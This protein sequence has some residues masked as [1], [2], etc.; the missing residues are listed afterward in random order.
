MEHTQQVKL[1]ERQKFFE[2]AFQQDME[3]YLSSGY[4]QIAERRGKWGCTPVGVWAEPLQSGCII[5]VIVLASSSS[6]GYS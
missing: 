1:R 4:L 3:Q 2:D 5:P 6:S